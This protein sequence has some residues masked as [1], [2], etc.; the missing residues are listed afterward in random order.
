MKKVQ[1]TFFTDIITQAHNNIQLCI[2]VKRQS[3]IY[4]AY[5]NNLVEE[6]LIP[7][8]EPSTA[9]EK[10]TT[11][12]VKNEPSTVLEKITTEL[13]KNE[14]STVLEK[15]TTELINNEPSTELEKL[16]IEPTSNAPSTTM[17][18][19]DET[20]TINILQKTT[21]D[22]LNFL[23]SQISTE[24]LEKKESSFP[25]YSNAISSNPTYPTENIT[26]DDIFII[27]KY[28]LMGYN[29]SQIYSKVTEYLN[30]DFSENNRQNIIYKG[31]NGFI[32]EITTEDNEKKIL[33]QKH[34]NTYNLSIID[35]GECHD[36]L[37]ARYFP[38][39]NGNISFIILKFENMTNIAS[40]KNVQFE[41]YDPFNYTK[42][43][44][45]ICENKP[46]NV[47]IQ[48]QLSESSQKLI[49][50]L[51]KLGFDVFNLNSP[52][53]TDFCTKYTTEAGTDISLNDRKKYIYDQIMNEVNCQEN[54]VL[55]NYNVDDRYAECSCKP[56]TN[57]D[58]VDYKK[59]K[60]QKL[61][62]TFYDVLKYSNYKVIQCYKLVFNADIF[63]Y[64]K[65]F[66]IIFILFILYL[67]QLA[68]YIFKKLEPLRLHI[69]RFHFKPIKINKN[70]ENKNIYKAFSSRNI[71]LIQEDGNTS[72]K[73]NYPPRKLKP[74]NL[75]NKYVGKNSESNVLDLKSKESNSPNKNNIKVSTK[76]T[77]KFSKKTNLDFSEIK[78]K[79]YKDKVQL[80]LTNLKFDDFELNN[81]EYE[82]ALRLDKRNFCKMYWSILKR[83]H[84]IIFTF[85][86]HNDYNLYYIK[87]AKFIFLL[88]T[89]MAMNVFFFSDETMNKLYLSYGK[90]DFVQQIPQIIYSKIVSIVVEI[91]LC[92]LSLTDKHYYQIKT[93]TKSEKEKIFDIIKFAR[94]KTII[95]FIL[96]FIIFLFYWYLVTAFCAV[97]E[98][99][100]ILYIKDSL[101]SFV[102]GIFTPLILY[103]FPALFRYI[104][105]RT[106]SGNCKCLYKLSEI[107]PIF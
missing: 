63:G 101:S 2:H 86:F 62:Q 57:I 36:L 60:V 52:F 85:F 78:P 53:Y 104:S 83:E 67:T 96:T 28:F 95:F 48:S 72:E 90:Y 15:I 6:C 94:R 39:I 75:K 79:K 25:D 70:D 34:L 105:L 24:K 47:Y 97:Y 68:V 99:T 16:N 91:F 66:F 7:D 19:N 26:S 74:L 54:C 56:E 3:L 103:F 10:I 98:N 51:E 1:C 30:Q 88:A 37:K 89:D 18:K 38:N 49:E 14:P 8:I 35:L 71:Q 23:S 5:N 106:K 13:I 64:N 61:Y 58:T 41:V 32:F 29:N 93:L 31:E 50:E 21:S 55:S 81:M 76:I 4:R 107:F 43:D 73:L 92:F 33:S 11:E 27:E 77:S 87:N 46:I 22:N 59:F 102:F 65:G 17:N 12:Q 40:E 20:D 100:Q 9:V 84:I 69:A 44:L 42:L 80:N 82:E 45:S